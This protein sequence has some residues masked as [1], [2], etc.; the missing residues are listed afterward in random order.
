M[1]KKELET[2]NELLTRENLFWK[3]Q[4]FKLAH[5][6]RKSQCDDALKYIHKIKKI[7]GENNNDN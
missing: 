7:L 1:T 6:I 3:G 5:I 2:M 4:F